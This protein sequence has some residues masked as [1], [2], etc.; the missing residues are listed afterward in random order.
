MVTL[1]ENAC[2]IAH[3]SG[4]LW[5][6]FYDSTSNNFEQALKYLQKN[7]LLDRFKTRCQK[8]VKNSKHRGR[9]FEDGMNDLFDEYYG[10]SE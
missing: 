3:D 2:Q 9:G 5:E 8:C 10:K 7:H 1:A 6:Q 4:N